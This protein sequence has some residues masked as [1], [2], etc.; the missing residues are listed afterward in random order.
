MLL[1][2]VG[3]GARIMGLIVVGPLIISFIG[4]SRRCL[5]SM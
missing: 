1:D 2:K 4:V 5:S 3:L